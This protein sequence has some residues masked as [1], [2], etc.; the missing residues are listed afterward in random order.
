MKKRKKEIR[1]NITVRFF[2]SEREIAETNA[3]E[4]G[5]TLSEYLRYSALNKNN[6]VVSSKPITQIETAYLVQITGAC[7]LLNQLTR[8][9]NTKNKFGT[10]SLDSDRNLIIKLCNL[11]D[12]LNNL[13][14]QVLIE[15]GARK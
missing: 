9:F 3:K 10:I 5:M 7:K 12:K 15:I 8:I 14:T 1:E 4:L 11:L 6:S 13:L 2:P